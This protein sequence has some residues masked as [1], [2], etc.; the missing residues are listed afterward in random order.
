VCLTLDPFKPRGCVRLVSQRAR[1]REFSALTNAEAEQI[2]DI[3]REVWQDT[4]W[5]LHER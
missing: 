2:E 3:Y 4:D 5:M 1:E